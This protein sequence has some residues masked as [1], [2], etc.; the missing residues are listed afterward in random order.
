[1]AGL[2]EHV[3]TLEL[4][5]FKSRRLQ[6]A[7]VGRQLT[8]IARDI[9]QLRHRARH[10]LNDVKAQPQAGWIDNERVTTVQKILREPPE[11]FGID[12]IVKKRALNPPLVGPLYRPLARINPDKLTHMP[13]IGNRQVPVPTKQLKHISTLQG[14]HTHALTQIGV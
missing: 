14:V 3:D 6:P 7:R 12:H 8:R 11:Q 13:H 2:W 9:K 5:K 1:M 4:A 10:N